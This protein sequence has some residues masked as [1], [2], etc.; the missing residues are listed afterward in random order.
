MVYISKKK[1][2]HEVLDKIFRLF[3]E[4]MSKSSN[5]GEFLDLA[6]EIFSPSEKIMMAKRITIIYLLVK[7]IDQIVITDVLKV[8]T[9]TVAKFALLNFQKDSKL[10]ELMR[11]MIK[12]EKVF[13]FIEDLIADLFIQPGIKIG[14]HKLH[15][16]QERKKQNRKL[17]G[18]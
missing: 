3:L 13:N 6:N 17:T 1:L 7:G 5:S 12:K 4:V 9:A 11:T 2:S 15:W 18:L 14:H 10:V 16:E 8:S